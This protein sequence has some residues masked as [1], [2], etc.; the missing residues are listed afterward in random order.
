MHSLGTAHLHGTDGA[1][2]SDAQAAH[3]YR[4]AALAGDADAMF[5]LGALYA[6]GRGVVR[7]PDV[8]TAVAL[9]VAA[10]RRGSARA[11]QRLTET[12]FA[13]M[14]AAERA[15]YRRPGYT[16]MVLWKSEAKRPHVYDPP[17][18]WTSSS[19]SS[20][21]KAATQGSAGF[22]FVPIATREAS[23]DQVMN[24]ITALPTFNTVSFEVR[25]RDT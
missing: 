9:Y 7:T 2:Q 25:E 1:V 12:A 4:Q 18:P 20:S 19:S 11:E 5:S 17:V 21:S 24:M 22:R 16:P 8:A 23:T 15:R 10:A 14:A 13:W 6:S 3:Y